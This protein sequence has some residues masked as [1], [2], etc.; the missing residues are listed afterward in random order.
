[1]LKYISIGRVLKPFRNDGTLLALTEAGL[2]KDMQNTKVIFVKVRGQAVPYFIENINFEND[3]AYIKFEEFNGPEEVRPFNDSELLMMESDIKY[4]TKENNEFSHK[5]L[6]GFYIYDLNTS[7]SVKIVSVEQFP[8]QL[9]AI[10]EY[11]NT[12]IHI[13]LIEAFLKSIDTEKNEIIMELP[14]G[15]F[16]L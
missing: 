13:P 14:D 9:M 15:I 16:N 7:L 3:L 11:N 4:G 1:M 6:A 8:Q 2:H 12:K 10:A 5:D